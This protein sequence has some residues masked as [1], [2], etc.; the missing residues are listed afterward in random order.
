M[1]MILLRDSTLTMQLDALQL[2]AHNTMLHSIRSNSDPDG[3]V[4]RRQYGTV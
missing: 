4:V 3:W 2:C 1:I